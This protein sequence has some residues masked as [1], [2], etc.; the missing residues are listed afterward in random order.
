MS[1]SINTGYTDTVTTTKNVAI[2][3][4]SYVSDFTVTTDTAKEAILTNITSP[5]DRV[6]TIRFGSTDIKDVYTG[7]GIDPAFMAPS[8]KGVSIVM[9]MN[10][11]WRYCDATNLAL[12]QIDLPISAHIVLKVPKTSYV[13]ADQFLSALTRA[14]S[15]AFATGSV[16]STRLYSLL[17]GALDPTE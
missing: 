1:Y 8:H 2:P 3:D 6:E 5:M 15:L 9:Q 10:D 4:L 17:K 14:F 11:I 7:T 13:T 16:T 12:P